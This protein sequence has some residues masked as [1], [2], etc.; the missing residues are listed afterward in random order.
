MKITGSGLYE[1]NTNKTINGSV[2]ERTNHNGKKV[3]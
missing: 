3:K 2:I 1:T